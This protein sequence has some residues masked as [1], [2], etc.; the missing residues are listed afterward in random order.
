MIARLHGIVDEVGAEELVVDVQGVGYRVFMSTL[1][2]QKVPRVGERVRLRIRTVVREDA[3]DL[4][5][6]H[7]VEEEALFDLLVSVSGVGPR[8]AMIILSGLETADLARAIKHGD[9]ARLKAIK[10]V[11]KKIAERLTVELR[12]RIDVAAGATLSPSVVRPLGPAADL[13]SGLINLGYKPAQA[14]RAAEQ[15]IT[16]LGADSPMEPLIREALKA[17]RQ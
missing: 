13:V 9:L 1:A 5:G 16:K 2:V 8:L 11:G 14:E 15:A 3:F 12:D 4:F 6:F 7:T 17:L 10:G